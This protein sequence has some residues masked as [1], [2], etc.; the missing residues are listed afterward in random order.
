[1]MLPVPLSA[2]TAVVVATDYVGGCGSMASILPCRPRHG[3]GGVR[4]GTHGGP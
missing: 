4:G 2:D 3:H 1:M